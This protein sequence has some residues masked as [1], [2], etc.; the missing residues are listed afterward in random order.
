[1]SSSR[2]IQ[3]IGLGS[4]ELTTLP[5]VQAPKSSPSPVE[6]GFD[7]TQMPYLRCT[8]LEGSGTT[9]K[10]V[11]G[12]SS[13]VSFNRLSF[14]RFT[15]SSPESA[16]KIMLVPVILYWNQRLLTHLEVLGSS[17]PN[18]FEYLLFPCNEL[19]NGKYT[20]GLGDIAFIMHYIVFWSL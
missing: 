7:V 12:C 18:P 14:F 11:D 6:S 3:Y 1:V 4:L 5:V 17:T 13:Q 15:D 8:K 2:R 20:K 19:P 10:Q 16:F 9:S